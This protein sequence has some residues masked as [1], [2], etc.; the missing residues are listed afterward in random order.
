M[1]PDSHNNNSF[2][3]QTEDVQPNNLNLIF[4]DKKPAAAKFNVYSIAN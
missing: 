1:S 2:F 3:S 4:K